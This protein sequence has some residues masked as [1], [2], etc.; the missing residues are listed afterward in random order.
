MYFYFL[1]LFSIFFLNTL[2]SNYRIVVKVYMFNKINNN[3]KIIIII[4]GVKAL[5]MSLDPILY[6][7]LQI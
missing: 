7:E 1:L 5:L 3:K 2:L 6:F 4:Q